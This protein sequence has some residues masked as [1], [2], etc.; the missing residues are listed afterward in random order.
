MSISINNKNER[1][2]FLFR[3]HYP[4]VRFNGTPS[5]P[6]LNP[7]NPALDLALEIMIYK[8]ALII[9]KKTSSNSIS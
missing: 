6:A 3:N 7:R 1:N 2:D 8:K 5:A 4:Y 9:M